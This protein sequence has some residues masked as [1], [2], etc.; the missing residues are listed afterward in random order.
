MQE[1]FIHYHLPVTVFTEEHNNDLDARIEGIRAL[2]REKRMEKTAAIERFPEF[3]LTGDDS[4]AV[5]RRLCE[6]YQSLTASL[7]I[8]DWHYHGEDGDS[9]TGVISIRSHEEGTEGVWFELDVVDQI[10]P[11]FSSK[12]VKPC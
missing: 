4:V 6:Q 2:A 12:V 5:S 8:Y 11:Y 1:V 7:G 3:A 9:R 10:R